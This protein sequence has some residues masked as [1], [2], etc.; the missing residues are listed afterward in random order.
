MSS[1]LALNN[2]SGGA[3]VGMFGPLVHFGGCL[4][5]WLQRKIT[6]LPRDVILGSGAGAAIAAV[7]SAPIGAA[8]F[9]HEAIIRRFGAFGPG[10]V[11]ACTF[12]S[13]WVSNQLLGD[14]RLFKVIDVPALDV[15]DIVIALVLGVA[16]GLISMLYIFAVT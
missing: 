9:A 8:V 14:H 5:E 12:A 16:S 15:Q 2:L 10:P 7:F 1:F 3:S 6:H 13:Y 4:S 11:L